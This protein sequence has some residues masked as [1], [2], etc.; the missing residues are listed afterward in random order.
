VRGHKIQEKFKKKPKSDFSLK[1][2]AFLAPPGV[3]GVAGAALRHW[4]DDAKSR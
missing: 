3:A 4:L 2:G 1:K